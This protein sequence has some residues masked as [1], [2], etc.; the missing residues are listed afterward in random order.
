MPATSTTIVRAW[1]EQ[2]YHRDILVIDED[3]VRCSDS[4]VQQV[5]GAHLMAGTS[6]PRMRID[7]K[8]FPEMVEFEII[9]AP[10]KYN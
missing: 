4:R 9:V 7:P 8:D 2:G 6:G 10:R 3:Q 5:S 1:N